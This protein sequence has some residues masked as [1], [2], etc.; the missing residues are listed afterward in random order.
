MDIHEIE[1]LRRRSEEEHRK[2]MEALDRVMRMM[3][4][5]PA[6]GPVVDAAPAGRPADSPE[7]K[8]ASPASNES[9]PDGLRSPS[10]AVRK[11]LRYVPDSSFTLFDVRAYIEKNFPLVDTSAANLSPTLARFA[12]QGTIEIIKKGAGSTPTVYRMRQRPIDSPR[13]AENGSD[14]PSAVA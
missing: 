3:K 7:P 6:A 8:I 10:V 1:E 13:F 11:A 12:K 2:D 9:T 14:S 5:A 4:L